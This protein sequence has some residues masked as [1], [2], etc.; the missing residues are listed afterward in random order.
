LT[1]AQGV[2]PKEVLE[3]FVKEDTSGARLTTEGWYRTAHFFVRP[4][5]ST[6][7][8][9]ILIVSEEEIAGSQL[10]HDGVVV[11]GVLESN[12]PHR[13]FWRAVPN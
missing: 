4:M 12:G 10:W 6:L 8:K 5:L 3:Q 1:R 2:S 13:K 11:G 9:K 7:D